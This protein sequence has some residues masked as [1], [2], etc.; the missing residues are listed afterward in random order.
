LRDVDIRDDDDDDDD[1]NG[2][3]DE[4]EDDVDEDNRRPWRPRCRKQATHVVIARTVIN[5]IP[6]E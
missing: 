3:G 1:D 6:R 4:D 5:R 2:D